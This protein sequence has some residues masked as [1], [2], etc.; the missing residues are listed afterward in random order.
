[1]KG[2]GAATKAKGGSTPGP[3]A[4]KEFAPPTTVDAWR[5]IHIPPLRSS[6]V[7]VRASQG[8]PRLRDSSNEVMAPFRRE[9]AAMC[10]SSGPPAWALLRAAER[11]P[12]LRG[13]GRKTS[14]A[15]LESSTTV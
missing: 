9:I 14:P 11:R 13:L 7:A 12:Q 4:A 10:V 15:L 8:L 2:F 6:R 1:L 3:L 5:K